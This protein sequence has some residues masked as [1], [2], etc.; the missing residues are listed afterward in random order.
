[1]LKILKKK[2]GIIGIFIQIIRNY[3]NKTIPR[4]G[5]MSSTQSLYISHSYSPKCF[6]P[7]P[8]EL[9]SQYPLLFLFPLLNLLFPLPS[10]ATYSAS[11]LLI[12]GAAHFDL[13]TSIC[14]P[15]SDT[16]QG[17]A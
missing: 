3:R 6:H 13:S 7:E 4:M 1:M 15:G 11:I 17:N 16:S 8:T 12:A 2:F 9:H 14:G 5:Q 10:S